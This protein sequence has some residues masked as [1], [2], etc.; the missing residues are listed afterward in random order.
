MQNGSIRIAA[1]LLVSS[2]FFL[3]GCTNKGNN[4]INSVP[5]LTVGIQNSPSNALVIIADQ[6]KFFDSSL[7]KVTVQ[8]FSA[9]KLALQAMLGNTNDIDAAVSAETPVVLSSMGGN[10]LKVISEIVDANNEIRVVVRKDADLSTPVSYFSKKRKLATSL[11]GSPEWSTF[12]F[13]KNNNIDK[14]NV[15]VVAMQPENMVPAISNGAVDAIAIFDPY[16]RM[17]EDGLGDQGQSFLNQDL[18]SYYVVSVKDTTLNKKGQALEAFL[19]GLIKAQD[20]IKSNPVEAKQ[21]IATR[22]KLDLNIVNETWNTY[23]FQLSLDNDFLNLC[24]KES[25]W[26]ITSGKYPT[27]TAIPNYSSILSPDLLKKIAPSAV[28]LK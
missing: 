6:K 8:E 16:A 3:S 7:V 22:T 13:L 5:T 23:N 27:G 4:S 26:A 21:I 28:S 18:K 9:G 24:N 12:N 10:K 11:G 1:I 17:A 20:F 19:R 14:N 15:E 2:S 25:Q